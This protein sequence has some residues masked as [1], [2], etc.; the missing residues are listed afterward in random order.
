MSENLQGRR[1]GLGRGLSALLDEE[2]DDR[3]TMDRLRGARTVP[4]DRLTPNPF[5]PRRHFAEEEMQELKR[6]SD[7]V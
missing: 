1:R 5:Q 6:R 3:A 2:P 4:V 7:A